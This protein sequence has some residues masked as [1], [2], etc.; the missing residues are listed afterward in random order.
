MAPL[1]AS[2]RSGSVAELLSNTVGS[3]GDQVSATFKSGRGS[4]II[5]VETS[6]PSYEYNLSIDGMSKYGQEQV[7]GYVFDLFDVMKREGAM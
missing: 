5:K 2:T 1:A 4:S 3:I 7:W 6:S